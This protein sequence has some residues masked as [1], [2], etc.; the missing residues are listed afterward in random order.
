LIPTNAP[1]PPPVDEQKPIVEEIRNGISEA[2]PLVSPPPAGAVQSVLSREEKIEYRDQDGNLLSPEQVKELE[3]KVSFK[4]RYE[5][6]TRLVDAQ[7]N[8]INPP[9]EAAGVAPPHPDVEGADSSTIG[10]SEPDSQ[11]EPASQKEVKADES[12]EESI[13][14]SDA[15]AAKPA[16]E[17]NDAT[18]N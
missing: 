3:G 4:T 14:K 2:P 18:A 8:E 11:A 13:A 1:I 12:K 15:G 5:T 17:G 10:K 6:R 16:S 7:G 9:P